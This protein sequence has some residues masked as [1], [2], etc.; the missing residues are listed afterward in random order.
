[1]KYSE[2]EKFLK[3]VKKIEGT[4]NPNEFTASTPALFKIFSDGSGSV[5]WN[6]KLVFYFY[7]ESN[8]QSKMNEY[9]KDNLCLIDQLYLYNKMY[10]DENE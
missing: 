5:L 3:F 7:G 6:D 1:M 2:I 4:K 9:I 8:L 10:G